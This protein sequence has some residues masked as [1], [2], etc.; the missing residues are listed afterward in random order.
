MFISKLELKNFKRFTDLTIDLSGEKT[1]PKLV[2]MIGANGSGKSSVFDVF[3]WLSSQR[4]DGTGIG[5]NYYPKTENLV[6]A[7]AYFSEARIIK[8]Q[9]N[10]ISYL[11]AEETSWV[12][13]SFYG[14]S[15]ARY[16]PDL[17]R[18]AQPRQ[19]DIER[20][21]D[22]PRS[23][24]QHDQRFEGDFAA[25]VK[26]LFS[27][28]FSPEFD[29]EQVKA[30]YIVPFNQSLERIFGT[31]RSTSLVMLEIVPALDGKPGEIKFR[32][33]QS[34]LNYDLLSS[35]EKEIINILLNL[36][37]RRQHFQD[38]IY[39]ID[40]LDV[41]LNTA[42]QFNLLKEVVE[43]WLPTN[44]Q[45]WTASHSLGFIQY[46]KESQQAAILDFDQLDFDQPQ[47]LTPQP[48]E[49][50]EIY[51]VA[52]PR[53]LML[54]VFHGKQ[55]FHCE[56]KNAKY[57]NLLGLDEKI[58]VGVQ[59]KRQVYLNTK[60]NPAYFGLMDRDYLTEPEIQKILIKLPNLRILRYYAFENYLYHPEN[61]A[62][63]FPDF[64]IVNYQSDIVRQKNEQRDFI[65]TGL[66]LAR[67]GYSVLNDENIERDKNGIETIV[68]ALQSDELENFYSYFDMK[69]RHNRH[70][71]GKLNLTE[72]KLAQT[73]WFK[74]AIS[75]IL[76]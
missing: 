59:D 4:K 13:L 17:S 63:I 50:L 53:E 39:F 61:I 65:L 76:I 66:E 34:I 40:E 26:L 71:V 51:E 52:V 69:T 12:P 30:K 27:E 48:K 56:N 5:G 49:V 64:D 29:A 60:H 55:I 62:E 16:T 10:S 72:S 9:N 28:L 22:R 33:G 74:S 45:L 3:E 35:G 75:K 44:C 14:R 46:A 57:Y 23:F 58:F 19:V 24:I 1:P 2:L 8:R 70:L 25:L 37:V 38:T 31:D 43:Y 54:K 73:K 21:S 41:H 47:T 18:T 36:F 6:E 67:R 32:K 15:A 42:L 20:D 68:T 11:P 7:T